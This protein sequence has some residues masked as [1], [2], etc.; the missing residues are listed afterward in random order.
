MQPIRSSI[1]HTASGNAL[2]DF[3]SMFEGAAANSAAESTAARPEWDAID[4]EQGCER[5]ELTMS[6]ALWDILL[7]YF[8]V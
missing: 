4:T 7:K 3:F 5:N 2:Q 1:N 8:L 6:Q